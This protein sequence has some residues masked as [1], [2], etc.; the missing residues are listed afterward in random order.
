MPVKS[1]SD[2]PNLHQPK[3]ANHQPKDHEPAKSKLFKNLA[4]FLHNHLPSW[5]VQQHKDEQT[6]SVNQQRY[7]CAGLDHSELNISVLQACAWLAAHARQD[8]LLFH[9][10]DPADTKPH[11]SYSDS[12]SE[13]VQEL[14]LNKL[15]GLDK[16]EAKLEHDTESLILDKHVQQLQ[17]QLTSV[18]V[19]KQLLRG[20]LHQA[21]TTLSPKMSLLVLGKYGENHGQQQLGSHIQ[22]CIKASPVPV[23]LVDKQFTPPSKVMLALPDAKHALPWLQRLIDSQLLLSLPIHL[24]SVSDKTTS[25][26]QLSGHSVSVDDMPDDAHAANASSASA[27]THDHAQTSPNYLQ[28]AAQRLLDTGH[29]IT[30]HRISDAQVSDALLDF[31]SLHGIDLLVVGGYDSRGLHHWQQLIRGSRSSKLIA[32]TQVS[33]LV[34]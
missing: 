5:R 20:H 27:N 25:A 18:K 23:W 26:E 8:V 10:T 29:Q 32:D 34:V 11:K 3:P 28:Q 2:Q 4:Y 24:V 31:V 14:L 9:V 6:S 33:V 16:Q 22:D 1:E 12:L 7:I 15:V 21:I 13:G 19:H 30:Q 17:N